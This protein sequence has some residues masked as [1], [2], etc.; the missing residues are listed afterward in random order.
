MPPN[1]VLTTLLTSCRA[2]CSVPQLKGKA[3]IDVICNPL[4][5]SGGALIQ[6]VMIVSFGSL[7]AS[8]PYLG[9]ILL[10]IVLIWLKSARSLDKQFTGTRPDW[11]SSCC[12]CVSPSTR[13]WQAAC[14]SVHA[15][16]REPRQ[17]C[18]SN[19]ID[20]SEAIPI[21]AAQK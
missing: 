11:H 5:K 8:T 2:A 3:A 19:Q 14:S 21:K 10:V 9:G 20:F 18:E 16:A 7:A 17:P 12:M 1:S 13:S 15:A 4:G 6:Q